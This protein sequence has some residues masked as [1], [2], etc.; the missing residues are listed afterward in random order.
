MSPKATRVS[1]FPV[2]RVCSKSSIAFEFFMPCDDRKDFSNLQQGMPALEV[3]EA[4][5][6][7]NTYF[8]HDVVYDKLL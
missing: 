1:V 5:K 2:V 7:S 4:L 3:L 6:D 8:V